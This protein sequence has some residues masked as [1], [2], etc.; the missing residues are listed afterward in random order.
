MSNGG[1]FF[2]GTADMIASR[3]SLLPI[4]R[5]PRRHSPAGFLP[6]GRTASPSKN[7]RSAE[8]RAV[9]R[10]AGGGPAGV[11]ECLLETVAAQ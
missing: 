5:M 11:G 2:K 4:L 6:A 9:C 8:D 1:S 7:A 3:W 10:L